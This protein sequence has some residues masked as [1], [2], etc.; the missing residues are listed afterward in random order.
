ME[1]IWL[2][3]PIQM[4]QTGGQLSDV[5]LANLQKKTPNVLTRGKL[6]TTLKKDDLVKH[7]TSADHRNALAFPRE[8]YRKLHLMRMNL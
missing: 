7:E 8:I 3:S 2:V 4:A 6:Y 5:L 1:I